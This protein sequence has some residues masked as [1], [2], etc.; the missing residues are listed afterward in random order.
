MT[1]GRAAKP[2]IGSLGGLVTDVLKS[3]IRWRREFEPTAA[4]WVG[5]DWLEH[6]EDLSPAG[7]SRRR[8]ELAQLSDSL[9]YLSN[10]ATAASDPRYVELLQFVAQKRLETFP[11]S[12][13]ERSLT[14]YLRHIVLAL[15][16]F[17]LLDRTERVENAL[18]IRLR[19]CANWLGVAAER[20][21]SGSLSVQP[22]DRRIATHISRMLDDEF[23]RMHRSA[24]NRLNQ[25]LEAILRLPD[26]NRSLRPGPVTD[27]ISY[28][29]EV[30]GLR[31]DVD[32]MAGR[33]LEALI[34]CVKGMSRVT[35]SPRGLTSGRVLD[36][37]D[38][39]SVS[40]ALDELRDKTEHELLQRLAPRPDVVPMPPILRP[41]LTSALF[42]PP[43][44]GRGISGN[45][46]GQILL[47]VSDSTS[48]PSSPQL[49]SA[50]STAMA[51]AHEGCPG[52]AEQLWRARQ[53]SLSELFLAA[54]SPI[55]LEGWACLAEN[56][57]A[58]LEASLP[59]VSGFQKAEM[60][61][62]LVATL[63]TFAETTPS[64]ERFVGEMDSALDRCHPSSRRRIETFAKS[65]R[66]FRH[67]VYALGVIETQS[68]I[69]SVRMRFPTLSTA[70]AHEK[71]LTIGPISPHLAASVIGGPKASEG[72]NR[73]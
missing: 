25:T 73:I 50:Y 30:L 71:Y 32:E 72:W 66:D 31:A 47:P 14:A 36:P 46:G 60:A 40:A 7:L 62:R 22:H 15:A 27:P 35:P 29:R 68:A 5:I 37:S 3:A 18:E 67:I 69:D 28:C 6:I 9:S 54:R 61:C 59:G 21:R 11:D 26:S 2:E 52:H 39:A 53:S 70:Q 10:D 63:N 1:L 55:G 4:T 45:S 64:C 24:G 48:S 65:R 49:E 19:A 56:S 8:A 13:F 38:S 43:F 12:A 51:L 57:V 20:A 17:H 44:F 33:V 34:D 16:P 41:F 23:S 58:H 42:F